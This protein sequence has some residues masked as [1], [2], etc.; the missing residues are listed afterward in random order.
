MIIHLISVPIKR[1][2]TLVSPSNITKY[3]AIFTFVVFAQVALAAECPTIQKSSQLN[4]NQRLLSFGTDFDIRSSGA[5]A[6]KVVQKVL[7]V[8]RTFELRN[9]KNELVA[10]A[11]QRVISLGVK[12]DVRDCNN[13]PIGSLQENIL[14]SLLKVQTVYSIFNGQNQ[15]V[16]QSVK[17]DWFGT[18]IRFYDSSGRLAATLSRPYWRLL[19]DKW[20]LSLGS[21]ALDQRVLLFAAA[22]K[23]TVDRERRDDS[24]K[25]SDNK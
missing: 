6:G 7:N 2:F 12:I 9:E 10:A 23:T 20:T 16:G 21:A 18:D 11:H 8:G 3:L 4:V 22:Y 1:A 19:V 15:L 5:P 13:Q 24:G 25:S 17:L 14:K